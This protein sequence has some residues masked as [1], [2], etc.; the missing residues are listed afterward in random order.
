MAI[1]K[2]VRNVAIVLVIAA[3]VVVIPGGGTGAS[4]AI[5]VVSLAFL[6]SIAWV[7]SLLYREHRMALFSLGDRRRAGLYAAAAVAAVTLTATH[8]LWG[9]AA[10]KIAWFALLIAAGYVAFSIVWAARRY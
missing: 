1:N 10:G 2:N 3:L 7:G 6:A 9:S 4:V 5:Q 8:R